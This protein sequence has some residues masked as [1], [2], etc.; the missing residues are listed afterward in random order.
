MKKARA[1]I[2]AE[3]IAKR[4]D[5]ARE[6][7]EQLT[8]LPSEDGEG[9]ELVPEKR[10]AGR[11]KG[12]KN[13]SSSQ[14]KAMLAAKGFRQPEDVLALM[15]GLDSRL[16]PHILAMQRT[17][18]VLAWA[19][20][21]HPGDFQAS[22]GQRLAVFTDLYK[23]MGRRAEAV[24]PFGLGKVTP[25][26]NVSNTNVTTILMPGGGGGSAPVVIEGGRGRAMA[27]PPMPKEIEQNQQ[28][29]ETERGDNSKDG[30]TV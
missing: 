22:V 4:L 30:R 26:V 3:K 6:M 9:G 13:K 16:P 12:A 23:D 5:Q 17:E 29:R 8:F 18:E 11:P 15:A 1:E 2:E 19:G 20:G 10:G 25:D 24:L 7:N 14:L 21:Q 27:P 28:V